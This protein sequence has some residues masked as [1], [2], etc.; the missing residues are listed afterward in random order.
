MLQSNSNVNKKDLVKNLAKVV[1]S[2]DVLVSL[3]DLIAYS[4]D[5]TGKRSFPDVVVFP[6]STSEVSAI[7][8]NKDIK[9][10]ASTQS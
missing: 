10:S 1:G 8:I 7:I 9:R 2:E 4:Y 5:G 6:E 3:T